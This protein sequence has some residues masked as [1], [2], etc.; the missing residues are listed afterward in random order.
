MVY[1]AEYVEGAVFAVNTDSELYVGMDEDLFT[2]EFV[3]QLDPTGAYEVGAVTDRA[4][5]RADGEGHFFL[6]DRGEMW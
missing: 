5:N 4:Y 3:A 6:A 2:F 1:A